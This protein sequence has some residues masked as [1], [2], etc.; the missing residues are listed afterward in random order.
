MT[1]GLERVDGGTSRPKRPDEVTPG[2]LTYDFDRQCLSVT[3]GGRRD[4]RPLLLTLALVMNAP[5][6]AH[7]E[8]DAE[9]REVTRQLLRSAADALEDAPAGAADEVQQTERAA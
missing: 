7:N 8:L 6:V 4:G 5:S 1:A 2:K 9:L 3:F